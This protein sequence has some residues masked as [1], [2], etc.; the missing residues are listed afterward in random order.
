MG[1]IVTAYREI[2]PSMLP[3]PGFR[4]TEGA[5][6]YEQQLDEV[7]KVQDC[8]LKVIKLRTT[9][10]RNDDTLTMSRRLDRTL[11]N[12]YRLLRKQTDL[13]PNFATVERGQ[14]Y[15]ET[16]DSYIEMQEM[17]LQAREKLRKIADNERVINAKDNPYRNISKAYARMV[18]AYQ[19][20]SEITNNEDLQRFCR[21]CDNMLKMQGYFLD[22]LHNPL[23]ADTD[24]KL[25]RET[26]IDKIKLI[27]GI[28]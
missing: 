16:L 21:Q 8:Y 19:G 26:A 28:K 18:K 23:A 3:V 13:R 11:A 20:V 5:L 1:D 9:I 4:D 6:I 25:K 7:R 22:A 14:R 15:I 12:G 17:C 24:S 27:I 10:A 2:E